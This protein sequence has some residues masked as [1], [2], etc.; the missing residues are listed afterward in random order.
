MALDWSA[1]GIHV[2]F[3]ARTVSRLGSIDDLLGSLAVPHRIVAESTIESWDPELRQLMAQRVR[4]GGHELYVFR[5]TQTARAR[6]AA[7]DTVKSDAND[8]CI[9]FAI[10]ATGRAHL[11]PLPAP[12]EDWFA[13]AGQ[14]NQDYNWLRRSGGKAALVAEAKRLLGPYRDLP[15]PAKV[16]FGNGKAFT[17]TV[18]A[19]TLFAVMHTSGRDEFERLLG[20]HA[21]AHPSLLRSDLHH[22]CLRHARKRGVTT[23]QYRKELRRLQAGLRSALEADS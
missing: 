11:Y 2:T 7:G 13:R 9:I 10:A 19:V 18:L 20:L 5:P 21:N 4:Q 3:D 8:A 12:D 1:N 15:E 17:P 22:H 16:A 6:K 14:L 23:Q